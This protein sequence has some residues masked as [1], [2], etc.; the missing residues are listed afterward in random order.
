[1]S[2]DNAQELFT[3]AI[4]LAEVVKKILKNT[5]RVNL[6]SNPFLERKSIVEFMGR[7]RIFGMEKFDNPTYIAVV[8]YYADRQNLEQK[9]AL[10]ALVCYV[11]QDYVARLV[12]LLQY[13]R[14]EDD[15]DEEALKDASGTLCNLFAGQFKSE[16]SK[17]GYIEL[18]MSAFE[19]FRNSSESGVAFCSGQT[20]KYEI[21]F[22]IEGFKRLVVDLTMGAV[23][24]V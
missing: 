12:R 3:Q 22:E 24:R 16:I 20:E 4:H 2:V 10:G 11:E 19:S 1:M 13:P 6:S 17:L 15:E 21:S 7:M 8:N 9:K 18:Q 5:G 23:P 14:L